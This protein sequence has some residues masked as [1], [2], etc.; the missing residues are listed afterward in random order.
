MYAAQE[1]ASRSCVFV[2]LLTK[3]IKDT[4]RVAPFIVIPGDELDEVVVESN[5]S[6]SIEDRGVVVAVQISGD[7]VVL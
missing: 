6:L 2:V 1:S 3:K 5:T 4:S 7:E